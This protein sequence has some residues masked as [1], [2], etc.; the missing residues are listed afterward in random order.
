M[1]GQQDPGSASLFLAESSRGYP[2]GVG[3]HAVPPRTPTAETAAHATAA[4][5]G[6]VVDQ[7]RG[8]VGQRAPVE[9]GQSDD[10]VVG[11]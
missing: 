5:I 6:P 1:P 11:T 4:V 9:G 10:G 3:V 8:Q 2:G 7:H